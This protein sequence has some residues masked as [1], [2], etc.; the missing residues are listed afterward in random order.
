MQRNEIECKNCLVTHKGELNEDGHPEIET[1]PCQGSDSCQVR[2]CGDC[3]Q[4]CALCGLPCCAEHLAPS[5]DPD[6]GG[7]MWC[8]LCRN[9]TEEFESAWSCCEPIPGRVKTAAV[10]LLMRASSGRLPLE[11][12]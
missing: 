1:W 9:L 7:E 8:A 3:L 12:I 5:P 6:C 11:V 4:K 10:K 2:M